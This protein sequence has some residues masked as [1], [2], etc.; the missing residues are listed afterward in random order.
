MQD[1]VMENDASYADWIEYEGQQ[2]QQS[3]NKCS[4]CQCRGQTGSSC[5]KARMRSVHD[6]SLQQID[7]LP[8]PVPGSLLCA[9]GQQDVEADAKE[10]ARAQCGPSTCRYR[11]AR[12]CAK[13]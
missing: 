12:A 1:S 10:Y 4:A 3:C 5:T 9:T 11:R 8:L 6:A 7:V 13:I 2:V